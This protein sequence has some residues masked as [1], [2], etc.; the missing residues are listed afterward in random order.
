MFLGA[1]TRRMPPEEPP[2]R[3]TKVV[4]SEYGEDPAPVVAAAAAYSHLPLEARLLT[5]DFLPCA[6]VAA[7]RAVDK[8]LAGACDARLEEGARRRAAVRAGVAEAAGLVRDIGFFLPGVHAFDITTAVL[9]GWIWNPRPSFTLSKTFHEDVRLVVKYDRP[10]ATGV[11]PTLHVEG[12][13]VRI[14]GTDEGRVLMHCRVNGAY[15]TESLGGILPQHRQQQRVRPPA[16][17]AL[18]LAPRRPGASPMS[19]R[20]FDLT[21]YAIAAARELT[22][23]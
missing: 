14:H 15:W 16:L 6:S 20:E 3:R 17:M 5:L 1:P 23:W 8:D 21:A 7:M 9:C 12:T 10:V 4:S 13:N 18:A 19:P 11:A 22:W 2:R